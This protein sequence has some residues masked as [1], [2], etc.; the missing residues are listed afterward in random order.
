MITI[1]RPF[2]GCEFHVQK[3]TR[4][5]LQHVPKVE[6]FYDVVVGMQVGNDVVW[7]HVAQGYDET[8]G[9]F[10]SVKG[11]DSLRVIYSLLLSGLD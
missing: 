4:F 8:Q 2:Y 6:S 7:D 1:E 10:R 3:V 11:E 9:T 5:C